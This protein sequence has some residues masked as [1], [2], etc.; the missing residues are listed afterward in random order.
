MH[1]HELLLQQDPMPRGGAQK[2]GARCGGG[3]LRRVGPGRAAAALPA[4]RSLA[5]WKGSS[6]ADVAKVLLAM[7]AQ[8]RR[9]LLEDYADYVGGG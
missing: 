1:R 3:V 2:R 9:A 4:L 6:D 7:S 5:A 8:E